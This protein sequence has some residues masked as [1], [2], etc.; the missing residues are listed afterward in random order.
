[1]RVLLDEC[2]PRRLKRDLI[3]HEV[4]IVPEMRWSGERNGELL[5]LAARDFDVFL[6]VD[7][8]FST[9]RGS[10][11]S[12]MICIVFAG[13]EDLGRGPAI[14]VIVLMAPGNRLLDLLPLV[15]GILEVL[16][17]AGPGPVRRWSS[18]AD[19]SPIG[20]APVEVRMIDREERARCAQPRS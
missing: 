10:R 11:C 1:M 7:R 18:V 17:R 4:H 9:N 14:V 5:R 8:A 2:L 15:P 13:T 19:R 16:P 6:T 20:A 12:R 3:G